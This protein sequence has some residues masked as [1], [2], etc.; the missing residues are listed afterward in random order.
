MQTVDDLGQ[1]QGAHPSRGQLDRQGHP[2][3]A[4]ANLTDRR[5]VAVIDGEI[6]SSTASAVD[7]QLDRLVGRRQ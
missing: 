1:R 7:K 3:Q 5:R 4:T 6:G 2:I